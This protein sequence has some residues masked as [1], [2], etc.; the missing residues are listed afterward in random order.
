MRTCAEPAG[1]GRVA[2]FG[3]LLAVAV[4]AVLAVVASACGADGQPGSAMAPSPVQREADDGPLPP[5]LEAEPE[6]S[7]ADSDDGPVLALDP[8]ESS[9]ADS[10]DGPVLALDSVEPSEADAEAEP[11]EPESSEADEPAL[12]A[13][14]SGPPYQAELP[15]GSFLLA[16]RIAQRM[17]L[18]QTLRLVLSVAPEGDS[19]PAMGDGWKQGVEEAA[20]RHGADIEAVVLGAA[21]ADPAARADEIDSLI[22][23]G[24]VDC[25]AV[26]APA[27]DAFGAEELA[28]V[29]DKAVNSGVAV[30]TV[31]AD[32][33]A[34]RRFAHYGLE[35]RAAGAFAGSVV[36]QW[37][38]DTGI[39]LRVGAVLALDAQDPA[40]RLRMEG[41]IEA[42]TRVLPDIYFLNGPDDAPSLGAGTGDVYAAFREWIL[43]HPDVDIALYAG[44]GLERVAAP[45]AELGLW[46]DVS[47]AGFEMS[48]TLG[49]YIRDGVVVAA[50][51]AD[52]AAAAAA[53]AGAC[54]DFL[55]V[56]VYET[57]QVPVDPVAVTEANVDDGPW[58]LEEQPS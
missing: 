48:E 37:S 14:P 55:L 46:G 27:P 53:A 17:N 20:E 41:F 9:E 8:V 25:L 22:V 5:D 56:G 23:A 50:M 51:V 12:G 45:V 35:D 43:A 21:G 26:E 38:A 24:D 36:G 2:R 10:D 40:S 6:S 18:N 52:P 47:V 30:F 28:R 29:M 31:G 15:W 7:E 3:V 34:S 11:S 42:I 13:L 32:S 54:A 1:S 19:D 49:N 4:V 39:W 33:A 57:G 16:G 44:P 58:A